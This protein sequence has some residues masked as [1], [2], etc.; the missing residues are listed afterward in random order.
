VW[1]GTDRVGQTALS[2][3]TREE[4]VYRQCNRVHIDRATRNV[5]Y[6][7]GMALWHGEDG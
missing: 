4:S 3:Q 6:L 7:N 1:T 5:H 2:A